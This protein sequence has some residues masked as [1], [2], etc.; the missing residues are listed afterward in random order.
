VCANAFFEA[1]IGDAGYSVLVKQIKTTLQQAS[2]ANFLSSVSGDFC[3]TP[4]AN[5]GNSFHSDGQTIG[6]LI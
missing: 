1:G 6:R 2:W 4:S 5:G 3:S